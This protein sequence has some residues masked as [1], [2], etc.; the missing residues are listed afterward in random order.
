M[1]R[2]V[3]AMLVSATAAAA[4]DKQQAAMRALEGEYLVK[5]L[6]SEG[7]AEPEEVVKLVAGVVIAGGKLTVRLPKKDDATT[8]TLDPTA[9]PARIDLA[10]PGMPGVVRPGIYKVEKDRLTILW[11]V[12]KDRPADFDGKGKGVVKMV[13]ERRPEKK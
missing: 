4:D 7:R 13:L 3:M 10:A 11:S 12:T 2:F 9:T 1:V 5:Q 6:F 8:F